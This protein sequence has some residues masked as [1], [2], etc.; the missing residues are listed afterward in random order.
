[1]KIFHIKSSDC[2]LEM[3]N[4]FADLIAAFAA[5]GIS[6]R[7]MMSASNRLAAHCA[8]LSI[9]CD[10]Q[11]FSGMFDLRTPQ[12]GQRLADKF[13][14][15][16][17]QTH[18]FDSG[19]V[20]AKIKGRGLRLGF[21]GDPQPDGKKHSDIVLSAGYGQ[22]GKKME[23]NV[24][25]VA[26]LVGNGHAAIAPAS[27]ADF[28]TPEN[29][30]LIGAMVDLN[31]QYG[32]AAPL[33]AIREIPELHFWIIGR[34][35]GKDALLEKARK[36][37]VYDRVHFIEAGDDTNWPSLLK[38]LD[39]CIVPRRKTGVDRLTL[40]AWSCGVCVLSGMPEGD[41]PVTHGVNGWLTQGSDALK[42]REALKRILP[43]AALRQKLALAGQEEYTKSY[44]AGK[45]VR[46]YLQSYETALR[47]K[48]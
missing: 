27:R 28:D 11:K 41:T 5:L 4:R 45:V 42:W 22:T 24:F 26:P 3:E 1:M 23:F 43:D 30:P 33:G 10:I 38:A 20:A 14:P 6:Q 46:S 7:V 31:G 34:G 44:A 48:A 40:E 39:L 29:K 13:D 19:M 36:Q 32:L 25:P 47:V 15:H 12:A 9:P 2:T 17:I 21:A 16:I 8:A 37:A 35:E 18:S